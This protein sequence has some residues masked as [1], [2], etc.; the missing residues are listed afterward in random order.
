MRTIAMLAVLAIAAGGGW[1]SRGWFEDAQR[2]TALEAARAATSQALARESVIAG[3]VEARLATLDAHQRVIDR[4]V[5][6]EIQKPIYRRVC[7][8][9][10]AVRLL[11]AAAAGRAPDPTDTA[12]PLPDDAAAAE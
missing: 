9:P 7:L 5:I 12:E 8:E 10:D 6:R 3:V 1:F 11:N 2:L 4:G